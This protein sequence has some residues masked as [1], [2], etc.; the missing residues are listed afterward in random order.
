MGTGETDT[1]CGKIFPPHHLHLLFSNPPSTIHTRFHRGTIYPPPG[2]TRPVRNQEGGQPNSAIDRDNHAGSHGKMGDWE[3]SMYMDSL[4]IEVKFLLR[5]DRCVCPLM[6]GTKCSVFKFVWLAGTMTEC[7]DFLRKC[8][9][10]RGELL[11]LY[12]HYRGN[13]ELIVINRCGGE[14]PPLFTDTEVNKCFSILTT[15]VNRQPQ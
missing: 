7:L 6:K 12:F 8:P 4:G 2:F 10:V 15:Q 5:R 11:E 14:Y 9:L 13:T 3:Q 1:G